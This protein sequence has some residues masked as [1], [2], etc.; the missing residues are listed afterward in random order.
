MLVLAAFFA[1]FDPQKCSKGGMDPEEPHY[2]V[3]Y[4]KASPGL[5][6]VWVFEWIGMQFCYVY[7]P[8]L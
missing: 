4:R 8:V 1:I 6:V 2:A 3:I 5:I 7:N